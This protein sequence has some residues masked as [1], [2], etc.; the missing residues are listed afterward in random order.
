M[1][2]LIADFPPLAFVDIET[3][4]GHSERDRITEVGV[5]TLQEGESFTWSRLINPEIPIPYNI[6]RLTG[7]S[8]QMVADQP[9]FDELAPE[10]LMQLRDKI[11]IAHNARFDYGFIKAAFKRM[12]IDFRSKVICTVKLSRLLYPEQSRHNLDTII[13]VHDLEV[14]A[15]HRALGDAELIA[16][17]WQKCIAQFGVQKVQNA[18]QELL[19]SPSL[20]PHIDAQLIEDIPEKPGV[21]IFYAENRRPL[22]IGKS[23]SLKS[24]VM[25]HFS[26]AL[27]VR[28]EMKLAMQVKDIDWIETEGEIGALLLESRLIKDKLPSMNVKLRRSKDLCAWQLVTN[29]QGVLTPQLVRHDNLKP[30]VQE[31]L[32]GLFYSR[33]E[34]LQTLQSLAKKNQLCEALLGLEKP[35]PG[36]PCF[37]YQVKQCSGACIGKE[38]L[39]HYHL[40]LHT[41]LLKFKVSIW[42]Y[43]GPIGIQEGKSLHLIDQWCYLGSAM[44]DDEVHEL[45]T[46]GQAEFDLDIFKIIKKHLQK[47]PREKIIA[48]QRPKRDQEVFE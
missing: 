30:G 31:D 42:P 21:Y 13:A 20:P 26:S 14:S 11:F 32:Y 46:S 18:V 6:Q 37:A 38:S 25:G 8:P 3:T 27:T 19:Q 10:L 40:R 41:V 48:L 23:N 9:R 36:K 45:L 29:E 15:R 33:R 7:I 1:N 2:S 39:A 16:Q 17:F 24:R 34:A 44:N 5:L 43:K 22:Y 35:L 47:L 12:G 28:K 4:G